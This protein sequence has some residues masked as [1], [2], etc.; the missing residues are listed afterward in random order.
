MTTLCIK[1]HSPCCLGLSENCGLLKQGFHK[2]WLSTSKVIGDAVRKLRVLSNSQAGQ[3]VG[4]WLWWPSEYSQ[5]GMK[6]PLCYFC[7]SQLTFAIFC[8]C[9]QGAPSLALRETLADRGKPSRRSCVAFGKRPYTTSSCLVKG[10]T[11]H[12]SSTAGGRGWQ[13]LAGGGGMSDYYVRT[14]CMLHI[15]SYNDVMNFSPQFLRHV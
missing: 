12:T 6:V 4:K 14:I 8:C 9:W 1:N 7:C 13:R 15:T 2:L 3:Q 11:C 10:Q 5:E